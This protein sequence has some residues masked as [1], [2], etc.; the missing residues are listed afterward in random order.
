MKALATI[1]EF[2]TGHSMWLV[3]AVG[4]LAGAAI[5]WSATD[6][7]WT[8]KHSLAEKD[9][10]DQQAAQDRANLSHA[11]QTVAWE[12]RS[13]ELAAEVDSAYQKGIEDGKKSLDADIAAIHDGSSR[14]RDK[15]RCPA[16]AKLP[17]PLPTT[18]PAPGGGDEAAPGGFQPADAEFL[19][20]FG[21]EANDVVRQLKACQ[22]YIIQQQRPVL[23]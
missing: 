4:L 12:R 1:G 23:P 20:R 10:A 5:G 9:W 6:M 13:A 11:E 14:M 8:T 21:H 17:N 19:V 2:I 18:G 22:D 3:L 7:V 15:F 16:P